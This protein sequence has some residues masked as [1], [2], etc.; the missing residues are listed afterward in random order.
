MAAA[1]EPMRWSGNG[2]ERSGVGSMVMR[3][4]AA[5]ET[6]RGLVSVPGYSLA[7][8]AG[9]PHRQVDGVMVGRPNCWEGWFSV[10]L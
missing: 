4:M 9:D 7:A 5:Q 1:L 8:V 10:S 6:Q 3:S 2:I